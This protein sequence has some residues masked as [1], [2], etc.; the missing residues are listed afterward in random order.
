MTPGPTLVFPLLTVMV[1]VT[2]PVPVVS[3][4]NVIDSDITDGKVPHPNTL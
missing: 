3:G 4:K 2:V 1:L